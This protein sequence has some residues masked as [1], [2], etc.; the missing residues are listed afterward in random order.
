[1]KRLLCAA[2]V[3][4]TVVLSGCAV[5]PAGYGPGYYGGEAAVAGPAVVVSPP[6]LY[7]G[8]RPY[9]GR[10]YCGRGWYGRGYR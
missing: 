7:V 1:M 10:G 4:A 8:P 6:P 2:A 5:Y 3:L 9:Y